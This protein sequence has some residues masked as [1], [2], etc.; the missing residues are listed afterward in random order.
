MSTVKP[1]LK[2]ALFLL[3]PILFLYGI[4]VAKNFLYPIAF[5]MLFAY[6]L[7][8]LVNWLEKFNIPRILSILTGIILIIGVIGGIFFIFYKQ[9]TYMFDEFG[10][11]KEK[12]NENIESLQSNLEE[13]FGLKNNR[14][15]DFLKQQVGQF[16]SKENDGFKKI[17]STTTGALL[18]ILILPVYIFLFLFYRTKFAYFI[19]KIV[20]KEN[21]HR[22]I[23]I[24]RDISTVAARYMGGMS[25]VVLI[26]CIINSSGLLIIG[27]KYAILLGIISAFFNFIPYFGTFIGGAIPLLFVLLTTDNPLKYAAQ[28]LLLYIIVQFTENNI[29]TP[30]IVGG[31][32]KINPFFIIVGLVAAGMVWGIPG[33]LLI[34]PFLAI[35]RIIFN[36]IPSFSPYSFL[37]GL[38]G[39][40][41]HALTLK[42][43][44][45]LFHFRKRTDEGEMEDQRREK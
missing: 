35:A 38:K 6:L 19:L 15:E 4:I 39:A 43:I 17:F 12:A 34:V 16:F 21:K 41:R 14:V 31:N 40:Q 13:V 26:L 18:R 28:V 27:V 33:M 25:I 10:T 23:K 24:L 45:N 11:L 20:D 36:N 32:V 1:S 9:L 44:K 8:P 30:N 29:L 42:N 37:L 22:A 2:V 7:Y 5:G 3:I